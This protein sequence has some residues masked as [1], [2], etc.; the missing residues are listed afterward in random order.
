[1]AG[2]G[3][4]R[5]RCGWAAVAAGLAMTWLAVRTSVGERAQRALDDVGRL[6]PRSVPFHGIKWVEPSDADCVQGE[7][8]AARSPMSYSTQPIKRASQPER[9]YLTVLGKSE[10]L[11]L[12]T[13]HTLEPLT[14][15][16]CKLTALQVGVL[17]AQPIGRR[18]GQAEEDARRRRSTG[19]VAVAV[20]CCTNT[21][22]PY[23]DPR[24]GP[25][26]CVGVAGFEPTTSSSR[27]KRA[28]K[29]R[30][31]PMSPESRRHRLL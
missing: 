19:F 10:P 5:A 7:T 9:E 18:E 17:G 1:M 20:R 31:T 28:A 23:P 30:Y 21:Q 27:T 13:G 24:I 15:F 25:L 26:T 8:V 12:E 14:P 11:R 22:R 16:H 4:S 3:G 2:W 6:C 29:L